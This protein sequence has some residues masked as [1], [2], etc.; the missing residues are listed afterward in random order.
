MSNKAV[1]GSKVHRGCSGLRSALALAMPAVIAIACSS[2]HETED[3]GEVRE[4]VSTTG[5][6]KATGGAK[7]T[8][9]KP[10][11]GGSKATGGAA[12]G[13]TKATGGH[14]DGQLCAATGSSME[15]PADSRA[16]GQ[17]GQF[18]TRHEPVVQHLSHEQQLRD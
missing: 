9:G 11:T 3:I 18:Y 15:Q 6:S 7:A 4:A 12:T 2:S 8:G 14:A 10:S 1:D 17:L 13:G 5:G 16:P